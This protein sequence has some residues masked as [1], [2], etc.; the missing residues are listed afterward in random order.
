MTQLNDESSGLGVTT[1]AL[2]VL[3]AL[4]LSGLISR[5]YSPD[6]S[7]PRLRRWYKALDKPRV[8]PPDAVFGAAWPVLLTGLGAGTFRL[9]RQRVS[10]ARTMALV[11]SGATL[12]LVTGYS[13]VA[14]GDRNLT[15]GVTESRALVG[16]SATYVAIASVSDRPAALLGLPLALWSCFGSWLTVELRVRNPLLDSGAE[17]ELPAVQVHTRTGVEW[18]PE[19]NL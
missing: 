15:S 18:A 2:I 7:H 14:F 9:L 19:H 5:R 8:T 6:P 11:L 13:K 4:S 12:G 10:P 16:V 17:S 3:G 1:S